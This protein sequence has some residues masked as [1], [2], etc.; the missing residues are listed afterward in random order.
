M[1]ISNAICESWW[2]I[3]VSCAESPQCMHTVL[4]LILS[5]LATNGQMRRK[6]VSAWLPG[7]FQALSHN[8]GPGPTPGS[9]DMECTSALLDL[10]SS[11]TL[12]IQCKTTN[13]SI[14]IFVRQISTLSL[15]LWSS[16]PPDLGVNFRLSH[17]ILIS[18][19]LGVPFSRQLAVSDIVVDVR[20]S[21]TK[22]SRKCCLPKTLRPKTHTATS[23]F[24]ASM[25]KFE[26]KFKSEFKSEDP[27]FDWRSLPSYVSCRTLLSLARLVRQV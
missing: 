1:L 15:Y 13:T 2:R 24:A 3:V 26:A 7:G 21:G 18:L 20:R 12:Q 27:G 19:F 16:R 23:H 25:A 17:L 8:E 6:E 4:S 14:S 22:A 10:Q 9:S 5:P 11:I